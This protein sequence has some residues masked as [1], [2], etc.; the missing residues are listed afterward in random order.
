[1]TYEMLYAVTK[2]T[3]DTATLDADL[4][5]L[6]ARGLLQQYIEEGTLHF[7]LHPIVRRYAYEQ[8]D[9]EER[10]QAHTILIGIFEAIT[11]PEQVKRIEELTPQ[12]ELYH[13][14][15]HAGRYD[16]ARRIFRDR[17]DRPT[18]YQFGAYDLQIDLLRGL[19]P[20]GEDRLP[21]LSDESD[22]A[23]TLND[24][25]LVYSMSGQPRRAIPLC[26]KYIAINERRSN[27]RN[28]AIGLGNLA[29]RQIETG[30]FRAAEATLRHRIALGQELGDASRE[31]PGHRELG[32]LLAYAGR[33]TEAEKALDAAMN[34]NEPRGDY[35]GQGLIWAHRALL[36]LLQSRAAGSSAS[37]SPALAHAQQALQLADETARTIHPV[38]RDYVRAHWLLGAAHL[39]GGNLPAADEHLSEALTRCRSINN[40]Q[41]E[42]DILLAIARL[43]LAQD[44]PTEAQTRAAEAQ[45]ISERSGYVLTDADARLVL[46]RLA[47]QAGNAAEARQQAEAARQLASCNDLPD[48]CYRVAYDEASAL[49]A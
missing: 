31:A 6:R 48:H 26:K 32:R 37:P 19:F 33:W 15:L 44:N 4:R 49:L 8:L 22:Q 17:I 24:L 12:I 21:R 14:L 42:P 41:L 3:G 9:P 25:A 30:Y 11:P 43:R 29:Q 16:E 5:A 35:Q 39:A 40:V 46:A 34:I 27:T 45:G 18:Y 7:D 2:Q 23:S 47:Q 20:D 38:E 10:Q 28:M 36:A 1:M 13:H